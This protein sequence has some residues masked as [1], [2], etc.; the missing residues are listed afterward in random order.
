M[1]IVRYTSVKK[2]IAK[3]IRDTKISDSSYLVDIK[4][5]IPEAMG[6]MEATESLVPRVCTAPIT[7][8]R[9]SIP[10]SARLVEAILLNGKRLQEGSAFEGVGRG[11]AGTSATTFF[12]TVVGNRGSFA[13][14]ETGD[15]ADPETLYQDARTFLVQYDTS[16][17]DNRNWYRVVGPGIIE[18]SAQEGTVDILYYEPEVDKD[19]YPMV[20]DNSAYIN[21]IYFYCRMKLTESGWQDPVFKYGDLEQRWEAS[22]VEGMHAISA[23]TPAKAERLRK[24]M[25]HLILPDHWES[26]FNYRG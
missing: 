25:Q 22:C 14:E 8:F 9:V 23:F 15:I 19:G 1:N 7:F 21:A 16:E 26:N 24:M 11:N 18:V 13:A 3:V 4:D 10:K 12:K 20:F 6:F 5:W 17:Y 2:V